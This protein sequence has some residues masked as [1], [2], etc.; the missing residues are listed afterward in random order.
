MIDQFYILILQI[1]L[2]WYTESL[3]A[4]S[5]VAIKGKSRDPNPGSPAYTLDHLTL[6]PLNYYVHSSTDRKLK[7]RG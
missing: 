3:T 5:Y 1:K 7:L 6:L 2:Y 4:Q